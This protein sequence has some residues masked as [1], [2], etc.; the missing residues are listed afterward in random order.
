MTRV[1]KKW[2]VPIAGYEAGRTKD[3]K[4]VVR[5]YGSYWHVPASASV[6]MHALLSEPKAKETKP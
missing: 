6:E 2:K 3:G 1:F 4:L 5:R